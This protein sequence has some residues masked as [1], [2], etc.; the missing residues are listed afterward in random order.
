MGATGLPL[1][2]WPEMGLGT[3]GTA[4]FGVTLEQ[5]PG[6]CCLTPALL[7]ID[8]NVELAGFS[9]FSVPAIS[10]WE[11]ELRGLAW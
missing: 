5:T 7:G 8:G 6:L 9:P 3:P 2:L 1:T 4:S 11:G 10:F